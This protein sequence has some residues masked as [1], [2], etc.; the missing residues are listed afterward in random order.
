MKLL[1]TVIVS[2]LLFGCD[3]TLEQ[4]PNNLQKGD[5][6]FAAKQ[7]RSGGILLR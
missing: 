4:A 7:Y 1:L 6:Y 3:N 5:E 2:M